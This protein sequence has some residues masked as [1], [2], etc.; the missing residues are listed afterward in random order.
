MVTKN[1]T[2]VAD[3]SAADLFASADVIEGF[4]LR[5]KAELIGV[6]FVITSVRFETNA[7]NVTLAYMTAMQRDGE[8]FEFSDSST[9]GVKAQIESYLLTRDSKVNVKGN[10]GEIFDVKLLAPNGLRVSKYEVE[11]QGKKREAK[12]Y[13][14]TAGNR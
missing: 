7:R 4:D 14:L 11:V 5:D 10:T 6:P 9:S 1:T 12:T 2:P 13:Y 3:M 8:R